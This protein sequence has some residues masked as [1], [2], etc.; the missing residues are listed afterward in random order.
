MQ[1]INDKHH[2]G[3]WIYLDDDDI[4]ILLPCLFARYTHERGL[5]IVRKV[6]HN[7]VTGVVEAHLEEIEIGGDAQCDRQRQLGLFLEWIEEHEHP[8][9]TLAW[10]TALPAV[11]INEYIN[12]HLIEKMQKSEIAV[13]KAVIALSSYYNWLTFLLDAPYKN[14]HIFSENRALARTNNK[15]KHIIK[16]LLPAT[17][18]LLY[19]HTNSYLEE[20]V[21][22]NGGELGCR[23]SENRG[24]Y[25]DDFTADGKKRDGVLRLFQQLTTFPAQEEFEYHLPSFDAKYGSRRTLYISREHLEMMER[26]YRTERPL[27]NS[28]HLLVSN[29]SNDTEG[30]PISRRYGSDLFAKTLKKVIEVMKNNPKAY[31]GYQSLDDANTYHHLRHSFGTDIFYELCIAAKKNY[32]SITTESRVYLETA[33]RM[34]HKADGKHGNQTTK[35]YIHACGQRE[36]LVRE[37][38]LA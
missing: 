5:S 29:S 10:H 9:V 36:A 26:Y 28:N 19:R 27:S 38:S 11:Y 34:G 24:F 6:K 37:V 31:S 15:S 7:E 18:E 8:S 30:Q 22:R 16:Y 35:I 23:T 12:C 17:R 2:N 14:I 20:I 32:E 25:L 3:H 1:K 33:R 21:L 13:N 4:P